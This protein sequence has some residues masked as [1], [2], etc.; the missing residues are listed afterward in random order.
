MR[1]RRSRHLVCHWAGGRLVVE[2]IATLRSIAAPP[3][4]L[5]LLHALDRWRSVE[6]L[7]RSVPGAGA[8]ALGR[9]LSALERHTLVER[10][11]RER[12]QERLL[13]GW[14]QWSPPA[15]FL[16]FSTKDAPYV[17]KLKTLAPAKLLDA[18]RSAEKRAKKKAA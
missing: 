4:A 5:E 8:A 6:E 1:F 14:G 15:A 17:D 7:A 12:P 3:L 9:A 16:H 10:A 11:G 18:Y 2:N 13:D